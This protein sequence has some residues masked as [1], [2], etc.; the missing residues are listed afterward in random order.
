MQKW[1]VGFA[2]GLLE[3]DGCDDYR[4]GR[5]R[6]ERS[7][8]ANAALQRMSDYDIVAVGSGEHC[9]NRQDEC[10]RACDRLAFEIPLG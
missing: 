5:Y 3:N 7:G 2:R 10:G 1:T 9:R 8:R 6:N 4:R